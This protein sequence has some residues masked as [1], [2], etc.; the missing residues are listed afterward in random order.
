MSGIIPCASMPGVLICEERT[1]D[2]IMEVHIK[3]N[4]CHWEVKPSQ[5]EHGAPNI[6]TEIF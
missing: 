1:P 6:T 4:Q 2:H 5:P 3:R